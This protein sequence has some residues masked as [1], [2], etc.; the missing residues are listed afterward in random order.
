MFSNHPVSLFSQISNRITAAALL[1]TTLSVTAWAQTNPFA[2]PAA[3]VQ[4]APDRD[5][6][7]QNVR[8]ITRVDYPN[9][10][11]YGRTQNTVSPLRSGL[12]ELRF[13][14]GESVIVSACTLNGKPT[15]F[16][17]DGEFVHVQSSAPLVSGKPVLAEITY[18]SGSKQGGTFGSGSGGFHWLSGSPSNPT[19]VGFWTQG[20]SDFNRDWAVTWDY[21][22]DFATTETVTTVPA[23][24]NVV[25]NGT[26]ISDVPVKGGKMRTVTWRMPQP[27]ATYLLSLVAGPLDM[28]TAQWE[29]VPLLYVVPRGRKALIPDSFSD[30]SDMM[31]FFSK[32][33]GVK[34]PWPKYSQNAMYE[35]GGGMENIS[36]TTLGERS[37]T[38]A[39]SGFRN[40][41]SLNAH[42]LA[43]QWFGDLVTCKTWGDTW[44]NESFATFFQALYFEH[45]RGKNAYDYE[46]DG[47]KDSY[48]AESRRY[49]RP[50][51]TNFY[52]DPDNM[53]DS[54]AYPKGGVVLHTLRRKLG[55]EAFFAGIKRYLTVNRHR[56]VETQDLIKA[57]TEASG[58]NVQP[59][60][61]QWIYKPGHPVLDWSYSYD[62]AAKEVVVSVKQTQDTKSGTPIYD[63]DTKIG[64]VV[65]G[66]LTRVP[67]TLDAPENTFRVPAPVK[68]DVVLFDV[69]RD[70]LREIAKE[71]YS[72]EAEYLAVMQYAPSAPDRQAALERLLAVNKG[73]LPDATIDAV[74]TTLRADGSRFPAFES[75]TNLGA[76][77]RESLR[78]FWREQLTHPDFARRAQAVEALGKLTPTEDDTRAL[79]AVINNT[80][81]YRAITAALRAL[82]AWDPKGNAD[83][84]AKAAA[85]PSLRE[86][87]REVALPLLAKS[88][89]ET[90]SRLAMGFIEPNNPVELRAVGIGTIGS[91][92]QKDDK[93]AQ[94]ILL[95]ALKEKDVTLV[96]AAARGIAA[97]G[98]KELLPELKALQT[99]PPPGGGRFFRAALAAYILELEKAS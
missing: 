81:P 11:I 34:Y 9:R 76:L 88:D 63:V 84:V 68:P 59:F 56:P 78:P 55:D 44:L 35:F 51:S 50:I 72:T 87:V 93:N 30:T 20:E 57:M 27:H 45:S 90:A 13:H 65:G 71:P 75:V 23:E 41:A 14:R 47:N 10:V 26:L 52:A 4:Y 7:L 74:V 18:T 36:S 19:R 17:V 15:E 25:G 69:D 37:L 80:A 53:F 29:D 31:T 94:G 61:D 12:R 49:K 91:V 54:H 85:M 38:D 40:M 97:L 67:V 22:N 32:V 2:A 96:L 95:S 86:Q 83:V 60:F 39:R 77:K 21:P 66:K 62:E 6:D 42:E 58:V 82:A 73:N 1:A 28:Q 79:R 5:Y 8:V 99:T 64:V 33:T 89:P 70:F 48:V 24:W 43:H 3:K 98:N 16:R 92:S 46:M